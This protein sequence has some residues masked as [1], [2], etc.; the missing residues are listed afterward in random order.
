[1]LDKNLNINFKKITMD[2]SQSQ[3]YNFNRG[4][5]LQFTDNNIKFRKLVS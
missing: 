1:V 5:N 4:A 3:K 2:S